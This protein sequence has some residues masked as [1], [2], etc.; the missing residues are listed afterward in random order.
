MKSWLQDNDTEM[1]SIHNKGKSAVSERFVRTIKNKIYKY[2]TSISKYVYID[3]LDDINQINNTYHST[4]KIKPF[5]VKSS[6]YI[7]FHEVNNKEYPKFKIG[8]RVKISNYTNIFVKGNAP[9]WSNED[10]VIKKVK[11][12]VWWTYVV[13]DLNEK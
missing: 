4:I 13:K 3:Q 1:Y 12:I 10:F 7:N 6:T 9:N 11:N 2:M 8:D 5:D